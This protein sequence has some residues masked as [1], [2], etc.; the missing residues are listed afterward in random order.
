MKIETMA[1]DAIMAPLH[2][3]NR[4]G[5]TVKILWAVL[6]LSIP[7][8]TITSFLMY[9]N[10]YLSKKW[11]QLQRPARRPAELATEATP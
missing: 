9:W 8:L 4:W 5:F 11:R 10:R 1:V 7:I 6:G 2:F 3:G